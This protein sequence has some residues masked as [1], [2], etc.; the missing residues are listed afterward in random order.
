MNNINETKYKNKE[1]MLLSDNLL[2][3]LSLKEED[4]NKAINI[5]YNYYKEIT[6]YYKN[7]IDD[8][9]TYF[10]AEDKNIAIK[11]IKELINKEQLQIKKETNYPK[12]KA[13]I[14]NEIK[15][16][17][18]N[19]LAKLENNDFSRNDI[20]YIIPIIRKKDKYIDEI[21]INLGNK[22]TLR[23]I[24]TVITRKIFEKDKN[25]EAYNMATDLNPIFSTPELQELLSSNN[26]INNIS[27]KK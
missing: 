6:Q 20:P 11:R 27:K 12:M 14:Y 26:T 8:I 9:L 21:I 25:D 3:L 16:Y 4:Y 2:K 24:T 17:L 22:E 5:I 13:E 10:N 15:Q 18:L 19:I 7:N 23:K 1:I